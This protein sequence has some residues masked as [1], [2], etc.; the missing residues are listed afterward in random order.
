[1]SS[2]AAQLR[3]SVLSSAIEEVRACA[4][5]RE[6]GCGGGN[7]DERARV[8]KGEVPAL[9]VRACVRACVCGGGG[10]GGMAGSPLTRLFLAV[11]S[12]FSRLFLAFSRQ[13]NGEKKARKQ[14]TSASIPIRPR[15]AS[16]PSRPFRVTLSACLP[17]ARRED[18]SL[19]RVVFLFL[20]QSQFLLLHP[21]RFPL[22]PLSPLLRLYPR[23]SSI[24]HS[25]SLS[26]I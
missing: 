11:Y 7:S 14:R 6:K 26:P 4:R 20:H 17:L 24:P 19:L 13:E 16:F 12:P 21:S 5:E 3:D 10:D 1:M 18:S 9:C 23:Y 22:P 25:F 8:R 15:R 2:Q